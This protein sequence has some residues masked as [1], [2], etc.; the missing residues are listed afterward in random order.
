MFKSDI[1]SLAEVQGL[2]SS[3]CKL[4]IIHCYPDDEEI[5]MFYNDVAN[6]LQT[7]IHFVSKLGKSQ[8]ETEEYIGN[9]NFDEQNERGLAFF[10]FHHVFA[11]TFFLN[12]KLVMNQSRQYDTK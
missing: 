3:K 7:H 2:A 9:Y 12:K 11:M 4:K 6:I 5:E 1:I 8:E 10:S